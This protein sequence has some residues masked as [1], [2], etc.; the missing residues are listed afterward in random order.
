MA[1]RTCKDIEIEELDEL[2]FQVTIQIF[3]IYDKDG[4]NV[5]INI[6]V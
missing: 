3:E 4:N 1:I 5:T 6:L 2:T